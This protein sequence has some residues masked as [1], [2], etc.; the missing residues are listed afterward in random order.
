MLYRPHVPEPDDP[1]LAEAL[2]LAARDAELRSWLE[3]HLAAQNALRRR[4]RSLPA[5]PDLPDRILAAPKIIPA[6]RWK[7][8]ATR[9]LAAAVFLLLGLV[10]SLT[11]FS[12]APDRFQNFQTRMVSSVLREYR[13]D[14]V[15]NRTE[16]VREFM[17]RRGAPASFAVPPRLE[18][19]DLTGGGLLRWRDHPVSMICYDRGTNEMIF[20]FVMSRQAAPDP[21]SATP[22]IQPVNKLITASWTRDDWIYFMAGTRSPGFPEDYLPEPAR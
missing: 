22:R 1:A 13:M 17:A 11:L 2:A 6:P 20:L 19:L 16:A 10:A 3:N 5:P 9:V 14:I 15:T 8:P 12:P 4:F 21:P 18:N 7:Q